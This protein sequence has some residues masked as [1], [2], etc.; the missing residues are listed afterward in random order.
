MNAEDYMS[1]AVAFIEPPDRLKCG[2]MNANDCIGLTPPFSVAARKRSLNHIDILTCGTM[3]AR[4][5]IAQDKCY[6]SQ[7]DG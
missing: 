5:H 7:K 6:G 4:D 2:I 3:N 1:S